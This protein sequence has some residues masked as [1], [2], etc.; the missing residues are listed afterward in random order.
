MLVLLGLLAQDRRR[1]IDQ[2]VT[3]LDELERE[4]RRLQ[5]T[6]HR[7][8]EAFAS[9]R[10]PQALLT[11]MVETAVD[12]LDASCGRARAGDDVVERASEGG[13]STR[14]ALALDAAEGAALASGSPAPVPYADAWALA[15]PLVTGDR[16]ADTRGVLAVARR[17]R[18]FTDQ[19]QALLGYLSGQAAV[20][21]DNARFYEE[22]SELARTLA[23]S[24][25][26]PAL[27]T[28]P[29]WRA[30]ALYRP[31]RRSDEVGGDVY[32]VFPIGDAWMVVIGDVIGKGPAAA[33][34]TGL[35][36]YSIRAGAAL[37]ASPAAA[38]R[39]LNDDLHREDQ[40]AI[41]SAACVLLREVQGRAVATLACAGHPPPIRVHAGEPR[42]VGKSSLLLGVEPEP[43]F[44][45]HTVVLD[46][47]D[48]LVLYTDG[49]LDVTG[50][51]ER[52]GERRLLDALSGRAASAE[53]ALEVIETR[54]ER[55]QDGP[56]P[57]DIA[58]VVLQR[59]R[60]P[61]ARG[62]SP[63]RRPLRARAA[64]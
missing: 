35:A 34:L 30:A 24:L 58:V 61:A 19:E 57:D 32:D 52:F 49:V 36:R 28:M 37:E 10:D 20:A 26:P 63:A 33:A 11:L 29:G 46:D 18:A 8:G 23:A 6:I 45:E 14:L 54:L 22:R 48:T 5:E 17:S 40:S 4:R 25:R 16:S 31:L 47:D 62:D 7:V 2:A 55:F 12:A 27:P 1:R 42:A 43:R 15:R 53:E 13:A 59:A 44:T 9:N 51:D 38:L 21:L 64:R 39:H 50:K 60:R 41:I 3:R 56:Q